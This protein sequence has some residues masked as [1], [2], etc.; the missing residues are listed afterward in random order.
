M[1][2]TNQRPP[3]PRGL[4]LLGNTIDFVRDP[5]GFVRE[6]VADTGD[7]FRM[8]LLGKDVYILA[9]PEYVETALLDRD[10]FVKL[11]DFKIAFGDA[12][13]SVHGD[14]WQRQRHAMEEFFSPARIAEHAET[15]T[16][17]AAA[18]IADWGNEEHI[19]IDQLMQAIALENLFEVVLGHSVSEP[20]LTELVETANTL[21]LWFKPS[22]WA[23][24]EWLPTPA[25][26]RFQRGSAEF[27]SIA[28]TLLSDGETKDADESLLARLAALRDAPDSEFTES[29]V[30]DQVVGMVFAGHET[31]ALTMA[32]ALHQI[33][34]HPTVAERVYAELDAVID[35][36]PT[37]ADLR[38]LEYLDQVLNETFRLYTRR[39]RASTPT[40]RGRG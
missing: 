5:L 22:S 36:Q 10:T 17:V 28:Q 27:R 38:Q 35:G 37:P 18:R 23:L 39:T 20:Q 3:T 14:Q 1:S 2:Q 19:Q 4:P 33:G 7:V 32:Y 34:S 11:D 9:H 26:R 13:L 21:N 8:Q 25:R 31:T 15:M 6:S 24:P 30:L 16:S 12:L 40:H 29:E